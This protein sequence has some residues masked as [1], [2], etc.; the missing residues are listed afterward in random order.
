MSVRRSVLVYR[1]ASLV[2]LLVIGIIAAVAAFH[3][4]ST[5]GVIVLSALSVA[6]ALSLFGTYLRLRLWHRQ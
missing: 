5:A 2:A 4:S 3:S 1:I 6:V